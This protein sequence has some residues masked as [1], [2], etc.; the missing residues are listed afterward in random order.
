MTRIIAFDA[1]DTLWHNEPVYRQVEQLYFERLDV[2]QVDRSKGTAVFHQ[3]EIENLGSFGYG[4]RG[5]IL[6]MIE[7]AIKLTDGQ[8]RGSDVQ[9]IID[10]GKWMMRHPIE[11][12]DGVEEILKSMAEYHLILITKGDALD[13]EEKLKRS[14]LEAYFASVEVLIDKTPKTY[15]KLLAAHAITPSDFIMIGNS[16]RSDILPVLELGG[17]AVYVPY[18]LIWAHE[19][20]DDKP[21]H[22]PHFYEIPN[23]Q[24][25]P[26]LL[27]RI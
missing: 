10:L 26:A 18:P 9:K 21:T 11:L 8:L 15:Q 20:L 27:N 13:Q 7:A 24:E 25:L 2:Y 19:A 22:D 4:I 1:D 5:F 6:S 16:L 12:L 23:L 14:G 3:I 17:T